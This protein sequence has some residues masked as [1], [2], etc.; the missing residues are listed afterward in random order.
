MNWYKF[1]QLIER[2]PQPAID[3]W[4]EEFKLKIK[5]RGNTI[6][7]ERK[8]EPFTFELY[9]GFD[10]NL[11]NLE[12][13]GNSYILSPK[14]SEQGMLWFTHDY[15]SGYDAKEYVAGRGEWLLT[16]PLNVTKHY[17]IVTYEDGSKEN[18]APDEINNQSDSLSNNRFRCMGNYCLELPEG[19]YWTYKTEKFIGTTN[20]IQV[21][22]NMLSRNI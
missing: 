17:D 16:Y 12:K 10:A 22:K 11:D 9:R 7:S 4:F 14:K 21:S 3:Q 5:Q 1:A 15:I 8:T 2:Q 18:I 19:W 13:S 20:K 6:S